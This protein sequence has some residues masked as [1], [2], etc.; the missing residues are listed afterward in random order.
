MESF[1]LDILTMQK[2]KNPRWFCCNAGLG[3]Q[4]QKMGRFV[5]L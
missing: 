4:Q 3:E 2:I 1:S 5:S